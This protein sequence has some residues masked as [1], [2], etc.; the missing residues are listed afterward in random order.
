[1]LTDIHKALN[2]IEKNFPDLA[3][4][5]YEIAGFVWMQGWNDMCNARAIPEYDKNLINLV[6]DLRKEFKSPD[7]P[8]VVGELGNGGPEATGNM[9]AFR[10]AQ[11][12]G[13]EQIDSA[14]FVI[15]HNFW[16]DPQQSPNVNQ[17]IA[18]DM[19]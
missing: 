13:A 1:M 11:K 2:N 19:G 3:S 6:N 17:K 14:V 8:V 9:A 15:T 5:E 16:R 7:L 18:G 10:K 12:K 4:R